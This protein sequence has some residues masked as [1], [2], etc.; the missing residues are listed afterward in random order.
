MKPKPAKTY[1]IEDAA[2]YLK[3]P[4]T[5]VR[6]HATSGALVPFRRRPTMFAKAALDDFKKLP[7]RLVGN[8]NLTRRV[9]KPLSEAE[10]KLVTRIYR[11]RQPQARQRTPAM[12][13]AFN[14]AAVLQFAQTEKVADVIRHTGLSRPTVLKWIAAANKR[15]VKALLDDYDNRGGM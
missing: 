12:L 8:P 11:D 14:I 2:G 9:L 5:A 3:M 10:K 7:R 4:V 6:K 1:N 13:V 15:G